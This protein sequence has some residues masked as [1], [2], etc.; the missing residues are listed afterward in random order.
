MN[1][2]GDCACD[3][4]EFIEENGQYPGAMITQN[5]AS[6]TSVNYDYSNG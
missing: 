5:R 3:A 1:D 2:I 4:F 6:Q